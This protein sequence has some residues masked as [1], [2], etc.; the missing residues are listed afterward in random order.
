MWFQKRKTIVVHDGIY[1][2][3]DVFACATLSL[4]FKKHNQSFKIIRTRDQKLIDAADIVVDVGGIYDAAKNRFDHHQLEG[5][6]K[7]DNGIPYASFGLVWE[8]Y[9]LDLCDG[10]KQVFEFM[11]LRIVQA[12]DATDNGVSICT[13]VFPGIMP[14]DFHSIISSFEPSWKESNSMLNPE[15]FD[16]IRFAKKIL[17]R[18]IKK[19]KDLKEG[20]I[21]V[22]Q[23]Y[24]NTIDKRLIML[25]R[26]YPW[27]KQIS[28]HPEPLF[29]VWSETPNKWLLV[30]AKDD[31]FSFSVR[32]N[33][34]QAWAGLRDT[35][36]QKVTGVADAVF[37]H[38]GLY[39][40]VAKSKEGIL[41]L[42][43][44]ALNA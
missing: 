8:T 18:L 29:V 25:D 10:N 26:Y 23:I 6:G 33:L 22:E 28:L 32:K 11:K 9:G 34:P 38:S 37:C 40:A 43:E 16:A 39:L 35:E 42:A 1:H 2:S 20:E 3:D 7:H 41:K 21:I 17:G 30:G 15:F 31:I 13:P 27:K 14:Y 4:Y 36:L 24:Q 19:T 44:M 5:A 12:I